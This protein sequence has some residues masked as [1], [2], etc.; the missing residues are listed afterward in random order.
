MNRFDV[1]GFGVLNVD[2]LFRVNRIAGE[3]EEIFIESQDETCGGS[4]NLLNNMEILSSGMNL[5]VPT[6]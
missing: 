6:S 3:Y 4:A 5:I 2:K 1:V